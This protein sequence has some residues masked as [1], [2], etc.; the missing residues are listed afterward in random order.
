[1][2]NIIIAYA[3][4]EPALQIRK[5]LLDNAF[6]VLSICR[7]GAGVLKL[8]GRLD[9]ALLICSDKLP[10]M[11]ALSL[12]EK[13]TGDFDMLVLQSARH[14]SYPFPCGVLTLPLPVNRMDLLDCVGMLLRAGA[15]P[16]PA[17][18]EPARRTGEE[19]AL[20]EKAKQALMERNG[21]AEAEAYRFLQKR[22]MNNCKRLA[23]IAQRVLEGW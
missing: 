10:D 11:P 14:G 7:T 5:L 17:E 6:P 18:R 2:K 12:W 3:R 4:R 13:L 22:S 1:M 19:Q 9:G 20:I 21:L 23:D 8:V 16:P 15:V